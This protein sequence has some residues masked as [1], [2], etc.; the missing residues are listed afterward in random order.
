MQRFFLCS[1]TALVALGVV[2]DEL[3]EAG[4]VDLIDQLGDLSVLLVKQR[5][6]ES[7]IV[8]IEHLLQDRQFAK[9]VGP[10][11][12]TG[13]DRFIHYMVHQKGFAQDKTWEAAF[14]LA[15]AMV[16]RA[17]QAGGKKLPTL[18]RVTR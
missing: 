15:Q 9:L 18:G 4:L 16:K 8:R 12:E 14:R 3:V 10:V 7:I 17:G 6:L 2:I 1:L 5:R 13:L 11:N